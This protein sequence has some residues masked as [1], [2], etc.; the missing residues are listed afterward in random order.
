M[1]PS[2]R[3]PILPRAVEANRAPRKPMIKAEAELAALDHVPEF[4]EY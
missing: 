1:T 4:V 3:F 2:A